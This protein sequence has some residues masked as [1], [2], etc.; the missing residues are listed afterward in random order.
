MIPIRDLFETHLTV[1]DL[2]RSV[3]LLVDALWRTPPGVLRRNSCRRPA[4]YFLQPCA[5]PAAGSKSEITSGR[6]TAHGRITQFWNLLMR[7]L[8]C[9]LLL[10][11]SAPAF[12]DTTYAL[13]DGLYTIDTTTGVATFVS[14]LTGADTT[15]AF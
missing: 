12:A 10:S 5:T 1:S 2:G 13:G 4:F 15:S 3:N 8:F 9:A 6:R 11:S 14:A 7:L